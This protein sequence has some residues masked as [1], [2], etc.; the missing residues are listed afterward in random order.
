MCSS[1]TKGVVEDGFNEGGG[2][3]FTT[4]GLFLT[5]LW[6]TYFTTNGYNW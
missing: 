2:V 1:L 3:V 4:N 6:L 5:V